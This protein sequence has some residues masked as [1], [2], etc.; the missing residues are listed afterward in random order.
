MVKLLKNGLRN[1]SSLLHLKLCECGLNSDDIVT[2][3]TTINNETNVLSV[4]IKG[5][6]FKDYE[7]FCDVLKIP[8]EKRTLYKQRKQEQLAKIGVDVFTNNRQ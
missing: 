5:N 3:L 7:K 6:N 8:S 2:L 4:H 1:M